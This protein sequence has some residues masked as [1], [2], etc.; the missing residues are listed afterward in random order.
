MFYMDSLDFE[1]YEKYHCRAIQQYLSN[2]RV[3]TSDVTWEV[4][5]LKSQSKQCGAKIWWSL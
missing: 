5:V 1:V 3:E 4:C 2:I